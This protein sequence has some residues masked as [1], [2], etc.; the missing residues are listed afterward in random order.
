MK[1]NIETV[2]IAEIIGGYIEDDEEKAQKVL[3]YVD[4][5]KTEVKGYIKKIIICGVVVMA[6]GTIM[7]LTYG[8][9]L[10]GVMYV[11]IAIM[12][13]GGGMFLEN[14]LRMGSIT[15]PTIIR[16]EAI[17]YMKNHNNDD[18]GDTE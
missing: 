7:M 2:D 4:S 10:M 6:L 5:T 16:K 15:R 8:N 11:G 13:F 12:A 17:E 1:K 14:Y 3:D 9:A 18:E